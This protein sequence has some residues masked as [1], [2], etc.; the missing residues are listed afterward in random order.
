MMSPHAYRSRISSTRL[1]YRSE[2]RNLQNRL[3]A[4]RRLRLLLRCSFHS[5]AFFELGGRAQTTRDRMKTQEFSW[6]FLSLVER[7]VL[8]TAMMTMI[9]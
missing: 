5:L 4:R 8:S 2:F 6:R 7:S 3:I 9:G 1:R